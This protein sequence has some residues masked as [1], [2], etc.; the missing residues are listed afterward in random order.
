MLQGVREKIP[1]LPDRRAGVTSVLEEF[2]HYRTGLV[3]KINVTIV[4]RAQ[5]CSVQRRESI[6][7]KVVRQAVCFCVRPGGPVSRLAAA[8]GV[9]GL[10]AFSAGHE[11][12]VFQGHVSM[13]AAR[14]D[15]EPCTP[16]G[17]PAFP[18]FIYLAQVSE[19]ENLGGIPSTRVVRVSISKWT[20]G[21]IVAAGH[22]FVSRNG[23]PGKYLGSA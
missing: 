9:E 5:V 8:L 2:V 14:R 17:G 19:F 6:S 12:S 16:K 20:V 7:E 15:G 21:N 13:L 18:T 23:A 1:Q 11:S 4:T 22:R 10:L 3:L